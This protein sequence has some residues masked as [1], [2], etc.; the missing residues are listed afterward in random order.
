M[1]EQQDDGVSRPDTQAYEKLTKKCSDLQHQAELSKK[2]HV[3]DMRNLRKELEMST[4][5]SATGYG[6]VSK[7]ENAMKEKEN[8]IRRLQVEL[9]SA[10]RYKQRAPVKVKSIE[11]APAKYVSPS[12]LDHLQYLSAKKENNSEAS[13]MS[14]HVEPGANIVGQFKVGERSKMERKRREITPEAVAVSGGIMRVADVNKNG[15]LSYTEITCMLEGSS[16]Q[17]FGRWMDLGKQKGFQ[18]YDLNKEGLIQG[19]ELQ[20][21]VADY[22][23][24]TGTR[25]STKKM[26]KQALKET[27]E[28]HKV[29]K[30]AAVKPIDKPIGKLTKDAASL[31]SVMDSEMSVKKSRSSFKKEVSSASRHLA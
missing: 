2:K 12:E 22:L 13:Q 25:E 18:K 6:E 29:A 19:D 17:D 31:R 8:E 30:K 27:A 23:F 15:G 5:R 20:H 1:K 24:L 28:K 3:Y 16:Y 7:M 10:K 4:Q 26:I 11:A 21:A 14:I 9:A